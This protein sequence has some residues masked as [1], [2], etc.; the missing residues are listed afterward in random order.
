M[1][2]KE[3]NHY[4]EALNESNG[5]GL[6]GVEKDMFDRASTL[7]NTIAQTRGALQDARDQVGRIEK[8][9]TQMEAVYKCLGDMLISAEGKRREATAAE[10]DR[11]GKQEADTV[12]ASEDE[13]VD[14][15]EVAA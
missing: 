5:K 3:Q 6:V 13:V 11:L 2:Q 4:I 10:L 14:A 1:N 8:R 15:S 9:L 12:N 7:T